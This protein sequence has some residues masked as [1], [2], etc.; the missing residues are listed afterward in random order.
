M[1]IVPVNQTTKRLYLCDIFD[2][3]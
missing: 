1:A 3:C 2:F